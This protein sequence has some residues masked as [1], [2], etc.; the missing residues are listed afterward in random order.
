MENGIFRMGNKKQQHKIDLRPISK[1]ESPLYIN[2]PWLVDKTL[3]EYPLQVDP[4]EK[5]DNVRIYI[6][7]DLNRDA[8]L[9]RLHVLIVHY[10]EATERNEI[11]FGTDV[12][13]LIS[14]IEIYDQIW[15]ARHMLSEGKHSAEAIELVK[16]FVA[17]LE[18]IPD[19][20][21]EQFPFRII[22]ELKQEYLVDNK[23]NCFST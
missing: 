7:M 19:G 14:Q 3:L 20:C 10:G 17:Y 12:D 15:S 18:E 1:D 22:E 11:D 5:K 8:I 13:L 4:D 6:P 2:E 23:E 9:R 16:E 21:A